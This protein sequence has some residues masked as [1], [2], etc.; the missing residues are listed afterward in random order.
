MKNFQVRPMKKKIRFS[1]NPHNSLHFGN[2]P[3]YLYMSNVQKIAKMQSFGK[4]CCG[5]NDFLD[6]S[7]LSNFSNL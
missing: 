5:T 7:I 2:F 6:L 3:E 4:N 1:E